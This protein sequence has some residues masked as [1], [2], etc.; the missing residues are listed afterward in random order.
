MNLNIKKGLHD[1]IEYSQ[2]NPTNYIINPVEH[3]EE[4]NSNSDNLQW[5]RQI[6]WHTGISSTNNQRRHK[7][8]FY[9]MQFATV[10]RPLTKDYCFMAFRP[11]PLFV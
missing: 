10:F 6:F 9:L 8:S 4:K 1:I 2:F 3:E 11:L 5:K 7:K